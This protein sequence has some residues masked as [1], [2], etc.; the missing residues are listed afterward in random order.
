MQNCQY[1]GMQPEDIMEC[2]PDDNYEKHKKEMEKVKI[3]AQITELQEKLK[4]YEYKRGKHDDKG[5]QKN[6]I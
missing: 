1:L 4:F 5:R 2:I 6:F 3:E